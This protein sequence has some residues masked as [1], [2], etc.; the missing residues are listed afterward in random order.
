MEKGVRGKMRERAFTVFFMFALTLV[1]VSAV[2]ALHLATRDTVARKAGMYL[3]RAVLAAAGLDGG[4]DDAGV[5]ALY[6]AA[7]TPEPD[8]ARPARYA[9]R[10]PDTGAP[11]ATV[12]PRAFPGLWGTIRATVGLGPDGATLTGVAFLEHNETPGLGA[13]VTE[14]WFEG[15]FAGK[16]GPFRLVPEG[17]RSAA[18]DEIDAVTGASITS[19]A[20]RDM[21]NALAREQTQ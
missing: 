2:S 11:R 20:V 7:V 15:Q 1:F 12:F 13:R 5:A 16:R 4:L 6:D 8:A 18:V 14:S 21:L 17:T 9:V 19:R 10:D 3:K